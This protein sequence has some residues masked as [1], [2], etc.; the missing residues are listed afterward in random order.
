MKKVL[1][2]LCLVATAAAAQEAKVTELMTHELPGMDGKEGTMIM[3]EYRRAGRTL[4]TGTMLL[5]SSM[6]WKG[7]W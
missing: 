1:I 5:R 4:S 7:Q 2:A 6:C 3:V